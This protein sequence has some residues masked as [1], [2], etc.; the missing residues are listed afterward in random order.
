VNL[1][2][3]DQVFRFETQP[4]APMLAHG[5]GVGPVARCTEPDISM[6]ASQACDAPGQPVRHTRNG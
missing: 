1:T 2:Y 3:R 4:G 5:P 6:R